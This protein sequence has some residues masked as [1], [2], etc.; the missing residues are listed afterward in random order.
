MLI[1]LIWS[2]HPAL[3]V[4]VTAAYV[5]A[6][7]WVMAYDVERLRWQREFSGWRAILRDRLARV[8]AP[9]PRR[10]RLGLLGAPPLASHLRLRLAQR[11]AASYRPHRSVRRPGAPYT[12]ERFSV[13][14]GGVKTR[15]QV[16]PLRSR[17]TR[18]P[19]GAPKHS[20]G[21][22]QPHE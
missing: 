1:D 8:A 3:L 21:R 15:R 10:P 11:A 22:K 6:L 2:A 13:G 12:G 18:A 9:A 7:M 14:E 17:P 16:R 4:A 5:A 20:T 19:A